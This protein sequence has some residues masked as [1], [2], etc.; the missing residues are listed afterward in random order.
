MTHER[1]SACRRPLLW[2]GSLLRCANP[3]L[4]HRP[5]AHHKETK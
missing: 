3:Q 4:H 2:V 5:P 1:C